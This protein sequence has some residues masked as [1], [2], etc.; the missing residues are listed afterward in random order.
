MIILSTSFHVCDLS[1]VSIE[2]ITCNKCVATDCQTIVVNSCSTSC[3]AVQACQI[4]SKFNIQYA[5]VI[6]YAD[7]IF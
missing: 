2:A 1:I 3:Y 7:V 5:V 4:F 6:N